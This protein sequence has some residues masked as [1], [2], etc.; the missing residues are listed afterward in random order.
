MTTGV[1]LFARLLKTLMD[2]FAE[3][4]LG[5]LTGFMA[6]ALVNL[7]PWQVGGALLSPGAWA[8]T[9]GS[10]ARIGLT[11]AMMAAGAVALWL[12]ARLRFQG[13]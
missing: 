5:F 3:P 11:L 13:S 6:G 4:V 8:G 7:W 10:P 9:T 12:L 2:R 1:A